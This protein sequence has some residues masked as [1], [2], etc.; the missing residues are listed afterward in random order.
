M[1]SPAKQKNRP[2]TTAE[3]ETAKRIRISPNEQQNQPETPKE[4]TQTEHNEI[5]LHEPEPDITSMAAPE[6][7]NAPYV[8]YRKWRK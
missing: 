8:D 3:M 4:N 7:I 1:L 2:D 5:F 6:L